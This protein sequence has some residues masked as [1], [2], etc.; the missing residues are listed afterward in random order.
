MWGLE[1]AI[2]TRLVDQLAKCRRPSRKPSV[3]EKAKETRQERF[4]PMPPNLSPSG[5]LGLLV[6]VILTHHLHPTNPHHPPPTRH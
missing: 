1:E 6:Y 5:R 3:A 2:A 4:Q